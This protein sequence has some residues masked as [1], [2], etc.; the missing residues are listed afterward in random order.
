MFLITRHREYYASARIQGIIRGFLARLLFQEKVRIYR[1][2]VMIQKLMRGKLGRIR[3]MRHYWLSRSVVKSATALADLVAR[4]RVVRS[5]GQE[6]GWKEMFDS[7]TFG[8]WYYHEHY[9]MNTWN[10]PLILQKELV[11]RWD[12]YHKFGGAPFQKRCR[13]V[14]DNMLEYQGHMMKAHRWYCPSCEA[15]NTGLVFPEC[16]TCGNTLSEEGES[17]VDV[18]LIRPVISIIKTCLFICT[19]NDYCDFCSVCCGCAVWS[20]C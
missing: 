1:A 20:S 17:A 8:F 16:A 10:C 2:T 7:V 5:D 4:S 15:K 13:C 3:W 11:C 6:R 9:G 14:F 12:G 19:L 18:S